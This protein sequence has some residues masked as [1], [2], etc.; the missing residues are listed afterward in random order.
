MYLGYGGCDGV[1][2]REKRKKN[3]VRFWRRGSVVL[4]RNELRFLVGSL[5]FFFFL[6]R[7][8]L[9]GGCFLF[10]FWY[11]DLGLFRVFLVMCGE[12]VL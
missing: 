3:K 9:W 8:G 4:L 5:D 1:F 10:I 12:W 2:F 7:S 6:T 11:L